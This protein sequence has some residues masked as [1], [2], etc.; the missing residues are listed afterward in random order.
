MNKVRAARTA[1]GD[2]RAQRPAAAPNRPTILPGRPR[3]CPA[4]KKVDGAQTPYGK[5]LRL[6][7]GQ[8]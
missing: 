1:G 8:L 2:G 6:L 5:G 4:Q 7:K 3:G